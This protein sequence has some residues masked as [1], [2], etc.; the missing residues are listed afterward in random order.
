[1]SSVFELDL[2]RMD[3]GYEISGLVQVA[4]CTKFP[5]SCGTSED[6]MCHLQIPDTFL[7][8]MGLHSGL[9]LFPL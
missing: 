2:K 3:T 1:M 9:T 4:T 6:R 5:I 8:S 7:E